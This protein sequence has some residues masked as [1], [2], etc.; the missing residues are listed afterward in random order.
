MPHPKVKISDNDGNTVAVDTSGASNALKVALV[1][2]D[3]NVGNVDI[4]LNGGVPLLG[5]IGSSGSGVLRV[6]IAT[7]DNVSLKLTSIRSDTNAIKTA[8]EKI[9]NA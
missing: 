7:D 3:L 1:A 2:G 4:H 6:T 9:D 8:V 5:N